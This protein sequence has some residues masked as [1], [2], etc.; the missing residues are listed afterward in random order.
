M[1]VKK[2]LAL[3]GGGIRGLATALILQAIEKSLPNP[4]CIDLAQTNILRDKFDLIAGTSTGSIL[5]AGIATGRPISEIIDLYIS[6]G[7]KIFKPK[8][9]VVTDRLLRTVRQGLSAPLHRDT[10]LGEVLKTVFMQNGQVIKLGDVDKSLLIQSYDVT[11]HEPVVFKS[12]STDPSVQEKPLWEVIKGSCSAPGYFPGHKLKRSSMV[13]KG[14]KEDAAMIDGGVFAN[15][16][17]L[18]GIVEIMSDGKTPA[19]SI[20]C[21]SVGTGEG[22]VDSISQ[23]KSGRMGFAEWGRPLL[24]IFMGG[25]SLHVHNLIDRLLTN[26]CYCR[27]EFISDKSLSLDDASSKYLK[28]LQDIANDYIE[29]KGKFVATEEKLKYDF[30]SNIEKVRNI[31][32]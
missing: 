12:H 13:I 14:K 29:G 15:N 21:V 17:A 5:A 10:G 9:I 6:Q 16:P 25:A 7:P 1:I 27:F 22:I 32:I 20:A 3:D 19:S 31:L 2:I 26:S 23:Q 30:K 8:A 24:G 4:E 28:Q 18:C 11:N